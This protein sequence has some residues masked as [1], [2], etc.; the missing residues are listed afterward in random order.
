M[1]SDPP[2]DGSSSRTRTA[3]NSPRTF[4]V[5]TEAGLVWTAPDDGTFTVVV[6]DLTQRGGPEFYYH[7]T[8]APPTPAATASISSHS[9][10]LDSGK[11]ADLKSTVTLTHGYQGKL[12]LAAKCLPDGIE[13][14]EVNVPKKGATSR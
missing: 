11:S 2:P 12:R 4:I 10:K 5:A 13:A 1:S 7:L 3:R 6:S 8:I 9:L 14:P